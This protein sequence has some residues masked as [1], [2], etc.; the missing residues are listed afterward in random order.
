M[1]EKKIALIGLD[2][3]HSVSFTKLIQG[4]A[5]DGGTIEGM[6][7]VKAMRFPSAFQDEE[8]QDKRQ[9]ELETLGVKMVPDVESVLENMDAV[10]LEVNDPSLHLDYFKKV[11]GAGLPVFIDKPLAENVRNA[12]RIVELAE[13][14]NIKAWCASGLRF[15]PALINA[16][17]SIS[18][19][20]SC[21]TFGALGKAAA[22]SD[23]T[24][25][26]V[27]SIEML[28]TLIGT[29]A[30]SVQAIETNRGIVMAVTY[31]NGRSGL[32]EC[33]RG[34]SEYGG[35]L[36]TKGS[37]AMFT[38]EKQSPRQGL[39][40]ALRDFVIEGKV[41]VPLSESLEIVAIIEAADRSLVSGRRE[42]IEC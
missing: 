31:A 42:N 11:V 13:K 38:N 22:G 33:L 5:P 6:R 8:G 29:G 39:I 1:N 25:Y 27:H 26:G 40:N 21:Y 7:I 37:V 34:C 3:S 20:H 28:T 36:H 14:H 4:S 16:K 10:F 12:R 24:W 30:E 19:P 18:D 15:L 9:A 2:T 32:V 23:L 17:E 35:R 41:P